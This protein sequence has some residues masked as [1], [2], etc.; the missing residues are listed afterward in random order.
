MTDCGC[1][2]EVHMANVPPPTIAYCLLHA[3]AE[4]MREVLQAIVDV[5][6]DGNSPTHLQA[7]AVLAK[8]PHAPPQAPTV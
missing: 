6:P 3:Q 4:A 7:K 8:I 1:R 2:V 5:I